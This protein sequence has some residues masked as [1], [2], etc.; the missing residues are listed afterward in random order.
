MAIAVGSGRAVRREIPSGVRPCESAGGW[1]AVRRSGLHPLM[2]CGMRRGLGTLGAVLGIGRGAR[3]GDWYHHAIV[4]MTRRIHWVFS[5]WLLVCLGCG[6]E[7]QAIQ[8]FYGDGLSLRFEGRVSVDERGIQRAQ[9]E[10][11]F[12]YPDGTLQAQGRFA[13][14]AVPGA[15][16]SLDGSTDIPTTG[17][18]GEWRAYRPGMGPDWRGNYTDGKRDGEFSFW[19]ENG[20]L[21]LRARFVNGKE[22]GA[23]RVYHENGELAFTGRYNDGRLDE[24]HEWYSQAGQ[25]LEQ[26]DWTEGRRVGLH[27]IWDE[28]GILREEAVYR[29]GLLNGMRTLWDTQGSP[30]M[31]GIYHEGR[32]HGEVT[33]FH[34]NG[35]K[36]SFGLYLEGRREGVHVAWDAAGNKR[37]EIEYRDGLPTG[38]RTQFYAGGQ[39]A[40]E[41][42]MEAGL[43]VG[44]HRVWS[45]TGEIMGE[46]QYDPTRAA[47]REAVRWRFWRSNPSSRGEAAAPN[48]VDGLLPAPGEE[49]DSGSPGDESDD[50]K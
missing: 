31:M 47:Q 44:R 37:A 14:G 22:N 15:E 41:G 28:A 26:G 45:D 25:L 11:T 17:R 9:G 48:P 33:L 42:S 38:E 34:A 32:P 7:T 43:P 49:Q 12:W 39:T 3:K 35:T 23:F 8:G 13:D 6:S 30:L 16:H 29:E 5:L 19:H 40:V 50:S 46:G 21:K 20:Q 10:W 27:R 36:K 4:N 24:R 2:W 18:V 1:D